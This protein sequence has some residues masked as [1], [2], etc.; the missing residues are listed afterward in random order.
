MKNIRILICLLTLIMAVGACVKLD[1]PAADK[2]Y[3]SISA[4]RT[5]EPKP[6]TGDLVIKVRRI[7]ISDLYSTRELV[8][9]MGDGRMESDFY[10]MFFVTPGNNLTSELR[11]WLRATGL[12]AHIIEPGSMVVP[13][14]TLESVANKLYGDYSTETPAAVVSMQF[15]LVDES[16]AHNEIVFSKSYEQRVPIDAPEPALLVEGMT[17]GVQTIFRQLE[18][19]MAAAP[20]K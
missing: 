14:L 6:A 17:K 8:Y 12:F 2:R 4:S 1:K 13:T 16:T 20:L 9:R 3:Y 18:Q 10:N 11:R 7:S 19:D 15:F 5:G